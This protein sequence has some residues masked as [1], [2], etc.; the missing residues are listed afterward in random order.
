M[1]LKSKSSINSRKGTD[2]LV[3]FLVWLFSFFAMI[4]LFLIL[5]DVVSKGYKNFNIN[6]FTRLL[7]FNGCFNCKY[8]W[9]P[10]P[11]GVLNGITGSILIVGLA[12]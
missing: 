9:N 10:I 1:S 2:K 6:L 11:G 12:Y 5:W 3:Y 8:E 4:P 7:L